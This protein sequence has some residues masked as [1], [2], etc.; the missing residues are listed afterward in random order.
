MFQPRTI[1]VVLSQPFHWETQDMDVPAN[2]SEGAPIITIRTLRLVQPHANG[3]TA[4]PPVFEC[5]IPLEVPAAEKMGSALLGRGVVTAPA[6]A[7]NSLGPRP[8]GP[9]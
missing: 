8:G 5:L 9:R 3:M 7:L 4:G 2:Q 1:S 6:S